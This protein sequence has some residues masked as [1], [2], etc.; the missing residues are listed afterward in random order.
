M[1]SKSARI[2]YSVKQ[3]GYRMDNW[4]LIVLIWQNQ[5]I[6]LFIKVS[7]LVLGATQPTIQ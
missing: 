2:A 1:L 7:R 5:E 4:D 3:L 6:F